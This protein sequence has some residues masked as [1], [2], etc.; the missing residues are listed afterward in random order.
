MGHRKRVKKDELQVP[1]LP[2]PAGR[3]RVLTAREFQ[4]LANVPPEAEWFANIDKAP[5]AAGISDRPQ[6][7]YGFCG[8][9]RK[10]F[11]S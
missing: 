2:V 11:T 4:G 7:L 3:S 9:G 5:D 10:N 6:R 1:M 8:R